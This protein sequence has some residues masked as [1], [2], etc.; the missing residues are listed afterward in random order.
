MIKNLRTWCSLWALI[1]SGRELEA[2]FEGLEVSLRAGCWQQ[3]LWQCGGVCCRAGCGSVLVVPLQL[4]PARL[5][6]WHRECLTDS[7]ASFCDL[8]VFYSVLQWVTDWC[9][10]V[11]KEN[12]RSASKNKVLF[13]RVKSMKVVCLHGESLYLVVPDLKTDFP[14]PPDPRMA[15][16]LPS[17][18]WCAAEVTLLLSELPAQACWCHWWNG[19]LME[20]F[21]EVGPVSN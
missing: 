15:L 13:V 5:G 16:H 11:A 4:Q 12:K 9:G 20:C 21:H 7:Q 1:K 6:L 17:L 3:G 18:N 10:W 14:L 2:F 19:S 8:G